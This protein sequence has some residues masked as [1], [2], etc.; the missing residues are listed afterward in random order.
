MIFGC[1]SDRINGI[2]IGNALYSNQTLKENKKLSELIKQTL[3]NNS[4]SLFELIEFPCGNASGCYDL[5][6]IL[7][8]IVYKTG[9]TNFIKMISTLEDKENLKSLI[10]VGFEY[11]NYENKKMEM[12][13]PKLAE[14]INQEDIM[15]K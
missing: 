10:E 12:E 11:G 9:E 13:F 15:Q 6:F 2:E 3:N 4:K 5:G 1:K 8:Q 7:T 14:Y